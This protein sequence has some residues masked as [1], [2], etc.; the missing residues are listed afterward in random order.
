MQIFSFICLQS[1]DWRHLSQYGLPLRGF[2][3]R[4]C[5]CILPVRVIIVRHRAAFLKILAAYQL[6]AV[7][8]G[9]LYTMRGSFAP[10]LRSENIRCTVR[11]CDTQLECSYQAFP[12]FLIRIRVRRHEWRKMETVSVFHIPDIPAVADLKHY[13]ILS[14]RKHIC[15]IKLYV[16]DL[17]VVIS[18]R[19]IQIM[20]A[21]T[22]SIDPCIELTETRCIQHCLFRLIMQFK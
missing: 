9:V 5:T 4:C 15:N 7:Y 19:R 13:S 11:I 16:L 18:P 21:H 10:L 8:V 14:F 6:R 2:C 1:F 3:I 12:E 20:I 17:L 22:T